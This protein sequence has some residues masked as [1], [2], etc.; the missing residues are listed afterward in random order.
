MI[1]DQLIFVTAKNIKLGEIRSNKN[2]VYLNIEDY[3]NIISELDPIDETIYLENQMELYQLI[4][5]NFTSDYFVCFR[6]FLTG[7]KMTELAAH[8]GITYRQFYYRVNQVTTFL[9]SRYNINLK[10]IKKLQ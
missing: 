3:Q 4:S 7:K 10:N 5:S 1:T 8:V 6:L 9:E 2:R